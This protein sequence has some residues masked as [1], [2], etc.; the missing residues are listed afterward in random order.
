MAAG[1]FGFGFH[2]GLPTEDAAVVFGSGFGV[3]GAQ[4]GRGVAKQVRANDDADVVQ[5]KALTSVDAPHLINALRKL[6]GF[7]CFWSICARCVANH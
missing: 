7:R 1:A 3:G 5:L 4:A 2:R 6:M